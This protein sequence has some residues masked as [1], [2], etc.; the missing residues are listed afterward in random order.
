MGRNFYELLD[1]PVTASHGAILD[2]YL[3]RLR[4]LR[5]DYKINSD[6]HMVRDLYVAYTVLSDA[7][8]RKKYDRALSS[9]LCPWCGKPLAVYDLHHHVAEHG[10]SHATDGCIVCGRLPT[11]RFK[12]RANTGLVLWR[13][14]HKVDGN[15]CKTCATGVFRAMQA[16]NLTRGPWSFISFFTTWPNLFRNWLAHRKARPMP[17][18]EPNDPLYDQGPG[19]GP[20]LWN[21]PAVWTSLVAV[22]A[23]V[24]L[25]AQVI[26][27]DGGQTSA[28]SDVVVEQPTSTTIDPH[29]GWDVG[30]CARFDGAG[31]VF[32]TSCGDHFATVIALAPTAPEC[33]ASTEW[34]LS[35][36]EGVAC[37]VEN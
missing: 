14:T 15:L 33:P 29:N 13:K 7:E 24:V 11:Q 21:K 9:E 26:L 17:D 5:P 22:A 16:R 3:A 18:P 4:E 36:D 20:T 34:S 2:A 12:Y 31:R 30:T 35:L 8:A 19:L 27:V 1:L 32:P 23:I 25:T 37:F 28:A 6:H 10:A